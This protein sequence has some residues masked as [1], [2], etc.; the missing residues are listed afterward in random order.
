MKTVPL[1]VF[2]LL[3]FSTCLIVA[4][5]AVTCRLIITVKDMDSIPISEASVRVTTKWGADDYRDV[6]P[7]LCTNS[8]GIV[9]YDNVYSV[10]GQA[11]VRVTKSAVQLADGDYS[12]SYPVTYVT[13]I[14]QGAASLVVHALDSSNQ[15]LQNAQVELDWQ[16]LDGVPWTLSQTTDDEG[17][18]VFPQMSPYT[19]Q[20]R[21][22]WQG[23]SVHQGSFDFS[24]V[25]SNYIAQCDVH[26]LQVGVVDAS[27]SSISDAKVTITRSDQL[28]LP[29]KYTVEGFTIFPQLPVSNY[30][31][32]VFYG[33]YSNAT[34]IALLTSQTLFIRIN[35]LTIPTYDV[36]ITAI[37][38]DAKPAP[39]ATVVVQ[40][41][42]G[43]R[44]FS[45]ITDPS[46]FA[47]VGLAEG[48]YTITVSK[49][50]AT[51]TQSVTINDKTTTMIVVLE[52]AQRISR[53]TVEVYNEDQF[54]YGSTVEL[55]SNGYSLCNLTAVDGM[56]NFDLPDGTYA[57]IARYEDQTQ[58][59]L[60]TLSEDIRLQMIFRII[61]EFDSP[62][63]IITAIAFSLI[64]FALLK[65][66]RNVAKDNVFHHLRTQ[67]G[68]EQDLGLT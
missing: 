38:S 36:T 52:T 16:G 59:A 33:T 26:N 10:E 9:V 63:T 6:T 25:S 29:T 67:S 61:G 8:S 5:S 31:I 3:L 7:M 12:L 56:V 55:C 1:A 27:N 30:T 15:S 23:L 65:L 47:T 32:S 60:V 51:K 62:I 46:G 49:G 45:G 17:N 4:H 18:S 48:A 50:N 54:A 24:S 28:K 14:C 2:A 13:V 40:N 22:F 53:L 35:L 66:R 34:T 57:V 44:L 58:T 41:I 37:W 11:H 39:A 68:N 64:L 20:V 21:V 42:E 19:Y 43:S